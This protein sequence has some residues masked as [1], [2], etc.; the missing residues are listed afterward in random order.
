MNSIIPLIGISKVSD[1]YDAYVLGFDGVLSKGNGFS[2]DALKAIRNLHAIGKEIV[3]CSNSSLRVKMMAELLSSVDLDLKNLRA[4]V[5][6]GEVLHYKLRLMKNLGRRY[7]SLG[8]LISDGVFEGLDYEKVQDLSQADFLFIGDVETDRQSLEDY[9]S[10]LKTALAMHLPLLC[11]GTDLSV[12]KND[13]IVLGSGAVAERYAMLGGKIITVGKPDPSFALYTKEAFSADKRK[14]IYVGDSLPSDMKSA[15]LI[16]ADKLLVAKGIHKNA[17]GE[18]YI[19]DIQKAKSLA[20]NYDTYP[21]YLI[22]E[23]RW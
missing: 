6:A 15:D 18:G 2:N 23:F 7:Y 11:V 12:H 16:G 1:L 22:S 17:L 3:I 9:E 5:T 10:D 13:D 20:Q 19:P 14:I 4:I 21:T 8:S